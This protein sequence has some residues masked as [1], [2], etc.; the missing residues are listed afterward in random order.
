MP[1][2]Y[3]IVDGK[4][5]ALSRNDCN[6]L[7]IEIILDIPL[8]IYMEN[9]CANSTRRYKELVKVMHNHD[10]HV[11]LDRDILETTLGIDSSP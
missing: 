11:C 1:R 10:E 7:I 4:K 8:Y 3:P 2:K 9:I 5:S 6:E